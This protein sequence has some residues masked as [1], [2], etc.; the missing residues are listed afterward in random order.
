MKKLLSVLSVLCLFCLT[1]CLF[2]ACG[3]K[4]A[5]LTL[6]YNEEGGTVTVSAPKSE[7][8]DI[9]VGE[10]VTVT[11]TK[12]GYVIGE[13]ISA[14]ITPKAGYLIGAVTLNGEALEVTEGSISFSL[15]KEEN[16]LSVTFKEDTRTTASVTIEETVGGTLSLPATDLRV[17]DTARLSLA[18]S[19]RRYRVASVT[20]N[21]KPLTPTADGYSVT[22]GVENVF[23]AV[24][25][26]IPNARFTFV[27][28]ESLGAL[29]LSAPEDPAYLVGDRVSATVRVQKRGDAVASLR[30]N[31]TQ[32]TPTNGVYFFTLAESN[33]IAVTYGAA[34]EV[35]IT[36]DCDRAFGKI[37]VSAPIDGARYLVGD[38]VTITVSPDDGAVIEAVTLNGEAVTPENGVYTVTLTEDTVVRATFGV[39]RMSDALFRTLTG[40]MRFR[41]SY[42]YDVMGS[43]EYDRT[44]IIDTIFAG[45]Y[46][47]QAESDAETGEL[48]YDNVY[49]RENRR[50]VLITHTSDNEILRS[51]SDELYEDYYNPFDRLSPEDF[52]YLGSGVF[53]LSDTAKAKAAASAL[54]GWNESMEDFLVYTENGA[55]TSVKFKT[56]LVR[57][58]EEI[59]YVSSY[60]FAILERGTA[61]VDR[62]RIEP[63]ERE[64]G[65]DALETALRAAAEA[66]S[67]TVR[68]RGHEVGYEEPE[69]GETRPGYGDTDYLVYV[70]RGD[71]IYDSY[72]GEEHGFKFLQS[73]VYPFEIDAAGRI[74]LL[75]PVDADGIAS[76]SA[77]FTAFKVELF[78]YVGDGVYVLHNNADAPVVVRHFGEGYEKSSYSY[79]TDC[80]ITLKD[81]VLSEIEF[82][83]SAPGIEETVRL[84]YT[85][86]DLPEEADLDFS[87]ATKTSVL[88]P[89]LGQY[90]DEAGNF[91]Q[92]DEKG[93]F[94]NGKDVTS[95][96]YLDGSA[97][98]AG[99]Y[100][101]KTIYIQ[102]LSSRQIV[103]WSEDGTLNLQLTDVTESEVAIP[104]AFRGTW[105]YH[106]FGEDGV[107]YDDVFEIQTHLIRYNGKV[108]KLLS[109]TPSEGVTAEADNVTYNFSIYGEML[110][111]L[112]V[113]DG[114]AEPF[115][116]KKTKDTAGIEIPTD[117]V[118]YY[119]SSDGKTCVIIS[120]EGITV[121]G[122]A[123]TIT[124]YT[125]AGGFTGTL[126]DVSG[127]VIQFYGFGGSVDMDKLM[128]GTAGNNTTLDRVNAVNEKYIGFWAS[129][130]EEWVIRITETEIVVNGVRVDFTF[131]PEYG[132]TFEYPGH[133]YTIYLLYHTTQYGNDALA[134]YDDN[135]LLYTLF[136]Y[137]LS[138]DN[139]Y[140]G[141]FEG[142]DTDGTGYRLTV[143]KD[144][145]ITLTVGDGE[146]V[147]TSVTEIQDVYIV[148]E[149]DGRECR[150]ICTAT[151]E[152]YKN[153]YSLWMDSEDESGLYIALTRRSEVTIPEEF[154][155]TWVSKDGDCTLV[156]TEDSLTM[157]KDGVEITA[158]KVWLDDNDM[159]FTVGEN[160][161]I[162]LSPNSYGVTRTHIYSEDFRSYHAE[163]ARTDA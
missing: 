105:E 7:S 72:P 110:M 64:S 12:A 148:F 62:D 28:D 126:G 33:E 10:T 18:P 120:Y 121:N 11:V 78:T 92:V 162:M 29:T 101:G 84:N 123:Y 102:K 113:K 91:C 52:I 111:V 112:I 16:V 130:G 142:T 42:L 49:G 71:M 90:R 137:V 145:T 58:S 66:G 89:F 132:Y 75:D 127:Y 8:E 103:I 39:G 4:D 32:I 146:P 100:D 1:V 31:G 63:Y 147:T 104:E 93:F 95:L 17:G 108:L 21:G 82:T 81:G 67:Y 80:K 115:T 97:C 34:A 45:D 156:I 56:V 87:D 54:T 83:Y 152:D 161:Y 53:R 160:T 73:Y 138:L 15:E 5:T 26:E 44:M 96:T 65:H 20:Q 85:F 23:H 14:E 163:I 153:E 143:A 74:V 154:R 125:S 61:E 35:D 70:H 141:S 116:V 118:G 149:I 119:L 47:W 98:F 94:L 106:G 46:I 122:V 9:K 50:L 77:N 128:V 13:T 158:S 19:S 43:D 3:E 41:G 136:P 79:A 37:T 134:L 135:D 25:E 107:Q 57:Y 60:D 140:V 30:V 48:Y 6:S 133:A 55:A 22:L 24:F 151:G 129:T 76:L 88:D 150:L 59:S 109:Y 124:S 69:G 40:V 155:G 139:D 27:N 144:G 157:T 86:G 114:E 68:H 2:T 117:Y 159:Y 99:V 38:T 36:T 131:N 51:L